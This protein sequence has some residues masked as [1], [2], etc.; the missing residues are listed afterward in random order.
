PVGD[1]LRARP[2]QTEPRDPVFLLVGVTHP[3]DQR[4]VLDLLRSADHEG[5]ALVSDPDVERASG[6]D[7]LSLPAVRRGREEDVGV[8][9][10]APN[11][12]A[13]A[14]APVSPLR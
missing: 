12:G 4:R 9:V 2:E 11:R 6:S 7:A 10:V 14:H 1:S 3:L 5:T 8:L 13:G